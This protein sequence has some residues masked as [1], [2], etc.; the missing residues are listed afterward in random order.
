MADPDQNP[1]I[2]SLDGTVQSRN[3]PLAGLASLQSTILPSRLKPDSQSPNNIPPPPGHALTGKQEH[4]ESNM[5]IAA[6]DWEYK[7][8]E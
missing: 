8:I 3:L 5:P 7:L 6:E 1:R 2:E 4:C